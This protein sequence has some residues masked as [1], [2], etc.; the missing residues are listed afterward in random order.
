MKATTPAITSP[1]GFRAAG[2]HCGLKKTN[3]PDLALILSDVPA[4]VAGVY[5]KNLV[6]GHSLQ[7]T[8][9]MIR[10]QSTTRGIIINSGNANACVG[11]VGYQ[12]DQDASAA[13]ASIIGCTPDDIL[14]C[15]TGVIGMRLDMKSLLSG[16]PALVAALSSSQEAGHNAMNAILTTDRVPKESSTVIEVG[17]TKITLSGMAK[18]SGM[19]HPNLATMISVMTTD[20]VISS[21]LLQELLRKAVSHTFN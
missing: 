14:T 2:I 3:A 10:Q 7:R 21:T 12:D 13:V 5:T 19:I 1:R 20:A 18:G 6:K 9:Q 17:G 4:Q 15:S 11:A 8:I 16:I